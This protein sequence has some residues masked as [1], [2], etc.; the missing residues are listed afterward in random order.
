MYQD[1]YKDELE[2]WEAK[3]ASARYCFS[4]IFNFLYFNL[5]VPWMQQSSA[6]GDGALKDSL[7][8]DK[9]SNDR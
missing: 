7:N 8:D 1:A 5:F 4:S 2:K 9:G 3:V 6:S